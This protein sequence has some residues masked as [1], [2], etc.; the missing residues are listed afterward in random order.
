MVTT[1]LHS[2]VT[3]LDMNICEH[4]LHEKCYE[5]VV[6][7][8]PNYGQNQYGGFG[9]NNYNNNSNVFGGRSAFGNSSGPM[10][11]NNNNSGGLWGRAQDLNN[12]GYQNTINIT[13]SNKQGTK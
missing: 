13:N 2:S 6:N 1:L 9:S 8:R 10:F 5:L 11:G 3:D 12:L 7:D 4:P